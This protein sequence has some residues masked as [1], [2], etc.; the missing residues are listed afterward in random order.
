MR[1]AILI[2]EQDVHK[3]LTIPDAIDSVELAFRELGEGRA[4]NHPR[5]R[6]RL[7]GTTL[8]YMV[9]AIPCLNAMGYK[10]YTV[11]RSGA[12]FLFML[13]STQ[14]GELLAIIEADRLGQMRT[15]AATGVATKYMAREDAKI[16]GIFGSG[17]QARSQLA[18]V[19]AVRKIT[20]VKV[21]S[22]K[23]EKRQAFAEEMSKQLGIDIIPVET[24][25]EA[26]RDSDI[27]ITIT[28]SKE[29]V[30]KGEWI[31]AGAHINAAGSNALIRSELDETTIKRSAIIAVDSRE[32]ARIECGDLLGPIERGIIRWE[33]TLE[34]AEIVC[35]RI[36]SRE[37][38]EQI[39]LFESQGLAVEDVAVA[40]RVYGL[41]LREQIGEEVP[42]LNS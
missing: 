6:I 28:T 18:A 8:H 42:L 13:Y 26:A 36:K 32:Q 20:G 9:A 4:I 21:Y 14:T 39:T 10:A 16:V 30:F 41:A 35:G 7:P 17:W 23:P 22:R 29:P 24:A 31:G 33:Q 37:S 19:C 3:L 38:D 27:I 15:G 25:E 12:K 40:A 1:M 11:S 5:Q 34:L 2:K